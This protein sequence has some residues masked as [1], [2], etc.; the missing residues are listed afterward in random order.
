MKR[1]LLFLV[2]ILF[3]SMGLWAQIEVWNATHLNNVRTDLGGSYIQMADIVLDGTWT[4]I[5]TFAGSYNGNGF[6]ITGL[7]SNTGGLFGVIDGANLDNVVLINT[8]IITSTAV[9]GGLVGHAKNSTIMNCYTDGGHLVQSGGSDVGG[10]VGILENS[11][12]EYCY[13]TITVMGN[14]R[15]GG[16]VGSTTL[17]PGLPVSSSTIYR[18]YSIGPVID[19]D[20][21]GG[22]VGLSGPGAMIEECYSANMVDGQFHIGG[23]VGINYGEILN[24]FTVCTEEVKGD[25]IG[26]LVGLNYGEIRNCYSNRIV[27]CIKIVDNEE[28]PGDHPGGLVGYHG[29]GGNYPLYGL[30]YNSYWDADVTPGGFTNYWTYDEP[31]PYD[32]NYESRTGYARTTEQMTWV[33][34]TNTYVTWDFDVIWA[35]DEVGTLN[36][37]YPTLANT[38]FYYECEP[39]T[40]QPVEL[41]SF[42]A[43][44][45]ASGAVNLQWRAESETNVLGYNVYRSEYNEL[46]DA[47][48][49]NHLVIL[50]MNGSTP[51]VYSYLDE[52]V[53]PGATYYYWLQSIDLD[54]TYIFHDPISVLI[55]YE[56]EDPEIPVVPLETKLIGAYPNPFNPGTNIGFSLAESARVTIT[57]YNN[58]GQFV[59]TL[60]ANKEFPEGRD[61]S[62]YFDG[63]NDLGKN[64][65]SGI[66]FYIM[67][68]DKDFSET[69]KMLLLK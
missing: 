14:D 45:I 49:I 25:Y 26:G 1:E 65:R 8:S 4:P 66:Y 7:S 58:R 5:S 61:H 24:S 18:C 9:V 22:L 12:M 56:E 3:M 2:L 67:Q 27:N 37:G 50:A 11:Q 59:R 39:D 35:A 69:R 36:R 40:G 52:D 28:V 63:K 51:T 57:I 21:V 42:T 64:I 54:L 34:A 55:S 60:I 20:T 23:L 17:W 10:L 19:T 38:A 47:T 31:D 43:N 48:N 15:V 41:S 62:V 44:V 46:N 32:A 6:T 13:N 33:H 53:L 68:T 29:P 30:I 16:L